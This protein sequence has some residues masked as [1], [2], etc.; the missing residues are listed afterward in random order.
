MPNFLALIGLAGI[1]FVGWWALAPK[2]P[3]AIDEAYV[4]CEEVWQSHLKPI[5][6]GAK[7]TFSEAASKNQGSGDEFAFVMTFGTIEG[8][9]RPKPDLLSGSTEA[10]AACVG[11]LSRRQIDF[12][13]VNG[14][15]VAEGIKF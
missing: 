13:T 7:L 15:D 14:E 4:A 11:S 3:S 1:I 8:A 6:P 2:E 10:S 12:A 9:R 5:S